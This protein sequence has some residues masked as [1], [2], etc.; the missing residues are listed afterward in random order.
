[1]MEGENV[2]RKGRRLYN[3]Q[4]F[5]HTHRKKDQWL[6]CGPFL[7]YC[8][9]LAKATCALATLQCIAVQKQNMLAHA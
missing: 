6:G 1:M 7:A 2:K 8:Q 9:K 4:L 3:M 5:L